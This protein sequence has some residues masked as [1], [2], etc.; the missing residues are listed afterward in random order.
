MPSPSSVVLDSDTGDYVVGNHHYPRVTK[1]LDVRFSPG[2]QAWHER[3]MVSEITKRICQMYCENEGIDA[4]DFCERLGRITRTVSKNVKELETTARDAGRRV[5]EDIAARLRGSPRP[6]GLSEVELIQSDHAINYVVSQRAVVVEVEQPV[7][8]SI[9]GERGV[10]GTPDV[11]LDLPCGARVLD[12]WKT[13]SSIQDDY[14][15]Q[16]VVYRR[17][18]NYTHRDENAVPVTGGSIIRLPKKRDEKPEVVPVTGDDELF[19]VFLACL[20]IF[21]HER[22]LDMGGLT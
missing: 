22:G 7:F 13:G 12:D 14:F 3:N 4:V 21:E 11:V 17:G 15:I 16:N 8:L 10:A 5:H 6:V 9:D 18:W 2:L 20:R 1:V 19:L